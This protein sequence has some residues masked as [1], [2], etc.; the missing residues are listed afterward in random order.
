VVFDLQLVEQVRL[1]RAGQL[2]SGGQ[3]PLVEVAGM[4]V[5]DGVEF[6]VRGELFRGIAADRVEHLEPGL[7]LGQ[8]PDLSGARRPRPLLS[9]MLVAALPTGSWRSGA[10]PSPCAKASI[11][12]DRASSRYVTGGRGR[13]SRSTVY[14]PAY[15][16]ALRQPAVGRRADAVPG[17]ILDEFVGES[18]AGRAGDLAWWLPY[19]VRRRPW[20]SFAV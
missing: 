3:R 13:L 8:S 7:V 16:R 18:P 20:P 5:P 10:R 12:T 15:L 19:R 11:G 1:G 2:R 14:D 9:M 6:A 4:A 17:P